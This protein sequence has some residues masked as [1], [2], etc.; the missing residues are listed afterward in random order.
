MPKEFSINAVFYASN[1]VKASF[2]T[3][4]HVQPGK[5]SVEGECIVKQDIIIVFCFILNTII[6]HGDNLFTLDEHYFV[7]QFESADEE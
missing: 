7:K 4:L 3:S 2:E 6:L 1:F 5:H